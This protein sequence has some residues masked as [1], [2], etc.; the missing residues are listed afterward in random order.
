MKVKNIGL[1]LFLLSLI[2]LN[3]TAETYPDC[4]TIT[5]ETLCTLS[6]QFV[7]QNFSIESNNCYW[8]GT[9]CL[10]ESRDCV[11][12][13]PLPECNRFP[14]PAWETNACSTLNETDC[15]NYYEWVLNFGFWVYNP[16]FYNQTSHNCYWNGTFCTTDTLECDYGQFNVSYFAPTTTFPCRMYITSSESGILGCDDNSCSQSLCLATNKDQF[17]SWKYTGFPLFSDISWKSIFTG[18]MFLIPIGFFV[19]VFVFSII[20]LFYLLTSWWGRR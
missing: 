13:I 5:N 15:N 8:N 2:I 11:F 18:I 7:E 12:F 3:T 1:G 17:I 16:W 9:D 20:L 4:T 19:C 10:P 14:L 6:Y